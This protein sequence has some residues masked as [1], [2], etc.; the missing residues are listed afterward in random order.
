MPE[1]SGPDEDST[2]AGGSSPVGSNPAEESTLES[3]STTAENGEPPPHH[4][5]GMIQEFTVA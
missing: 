4:V 3:G 1:N 5:L 2:L